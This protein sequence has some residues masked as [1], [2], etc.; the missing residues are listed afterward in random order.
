MLDLIDTIHTIQFKNICD[1]L[2]VII[3][4]PRLDSVRPTRTKL[5]I[6]QKKL[7]S[8]VGVSTSM[9]NQIESGRCSPSYDTACKIFESLASLEKSTATHIAGDLCNREIVKLRPNDTMHAAV[10]LLRK[11]SISQIPVFDSKRIVGIIS[12]DGIMRQLADKDTDLHHVYVRDVM[13]VAPPI[14][15]Y[16]TPVRALASL[17]RITKCIM[18]SENSIIIGI[19]TSADTLKIL[20]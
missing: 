4:L 3:M 7:A 12:E 14:V 2:F 20:E 10:A 6:T 17:I 15:D 13:D 19:I 5:G 8:L 1:P 16:Q 9:I 18:V 11:Y